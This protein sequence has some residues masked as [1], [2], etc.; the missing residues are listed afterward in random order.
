MLSITEIS[1]FLQKL[2]NLSIAQ[3][4]EKD[5]GPQAGHEE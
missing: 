2:S 4:K 3:N 1:Q 5:F